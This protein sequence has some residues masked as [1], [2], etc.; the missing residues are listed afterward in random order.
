[1]TGNNIMY[2]KSALLEALN[3][4]E[5]EDY[6]NIIP[7]NS[8]FTMYQNVPIIASKENIEDG[9]KMVMGRLI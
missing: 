6:F 4:L 7:F 5:E 1:M 3:V 9:K 2:A 8:G